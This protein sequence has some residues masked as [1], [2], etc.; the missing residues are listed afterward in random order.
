MT[1]SIVPASAGPRETT[2]LAT[3]GSAVRTILRAEGLPIFIAGVVGF[4]A[5][6]GPWLAFVPLLLAPDLSAI[7]YV[8]G[9]RLGSMTYNL[10]H[11]L[12]TAGAL[13]GL[14]LG[15]GVGWLA[16]AGTVAVAHIGM[17]RLSGYGL[18]Y[19]TTFKD[20]HLQHV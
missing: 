8:R 15:L 4:G 6:G 20:T 17:D 16:I 1:A 11:N 18:K 3:P 12:V 9:T 10:A 5:L 19:P 7:G 13:L 14:G 2:S